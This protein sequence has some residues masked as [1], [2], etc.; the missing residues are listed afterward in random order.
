MRRSILIAVAMTVIL[1]GCGGGG[2]K[3]SEPPWVIIEAWRVVGSLPINI[4]IDYPSCFNDPG[5]PVQVT[6][7]IPQ[8]INPDIPPSFVWAEVFLR[9][10][11]KFLAVPVWK[12]GLSWFLLTNQPV[13]LKDVEKIVV[14]YQCPNR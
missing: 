14:H 2:N 13:P 8:S 11:E 4:T 10:G 5:M 3:S 12:N 6:T 7:S 9:G 1:A